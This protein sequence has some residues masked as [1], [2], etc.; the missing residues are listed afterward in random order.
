[1][2]TYILALPGMEVVRLLRAET[3][4]AHG[5]PELNVSVWQEYVIEEQFERSAYSLHDGEEFDLVTAV[6]IL[7]I[8]PRRE[9]DYWTLRTIVERA[10]G[11]VAAR[12]EGAFARSE[13]TLDAFDAELRSTG[14]KL[15]TVRLDAETVTAKE[16]FDR[17]LADMRA[18]HPA[19]APPG[20]K[21]AEAEGAAVSA[22]EQADTSE[23]APSRTRWTYGAKEAV[24]V[25]ADADALERAVDELELSGFDRAALSVLSA[26]ARAKGRVEGLYRPIA[27]IEDSTDAR[28][29][30]FVSRNSR[31]E[32][33]AA[34][35]GAP[36]YVGGIA[37]AFAV[38][39]TGGAL[40]PAF[41]AA[42]A[43]GAAGAGLGT[44][45]ATAIARRHVARVQAQLMQGGL[46][47]WVG[48]ADPATEKRALAILQKTGA[49]DVHVHELHREWSMRDLPVGHFQFDPLLERDP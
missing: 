23:A 14:S 3:E 43:G 19:A 9:R 29:G 35:I 48:V 11:P 26:D 22:P 16:H 7:S 20:R 47:L 8:E 45:L 38:I 44:L 33:E 31:T 10:L 24:G 41:A 36:F 30:A 37:G 18:R 25:F 21:R 6:A 28:R 32:G 27:E 49:R 12:Q 13:M 39:A 46:V 42:I 40:A 1:M 2:P 5:Q 34:A 4:A 17:W 15:I